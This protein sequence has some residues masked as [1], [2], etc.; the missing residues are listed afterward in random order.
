M[1]CFLIV[2]GM[3]CLTDIHFSSV[4]L[5][6]EKP[7]LESFCL[8][9]VLLHRWARVVETNDLSMYNIEGDKDVGHFL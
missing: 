3:A 1:D 4:Y 7:L 9:K 2:F 6:K 8:I 5:E